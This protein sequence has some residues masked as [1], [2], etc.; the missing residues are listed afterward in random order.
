MHFSRVLKIEEHSCSSIIMLQGDSYLKGHPMSDKDSS[1]DAMKDIV[2]SNT[3]VNDEEAEEFAKKI[4][5][6]AAS[7][8]GVKI[9][10]GTF[11]RTTLKK[12]CPEID[13][14]R[15]VETTP[16]EAGVSAE[17]I[18]IMA[19]MVIDF[20]TKKCAGLSFLAGVP[21]GVA[22]FGTVPADLAQYFAHVMR[23]EQKLAYLY[24]WQT[25]LDDTDEVDDETIMELVVLMGV[26]LQVGGAAATITKFAT[27][28]AQ[29][30]VAK[31]IQRQALTKTTFYPIMKSVLRVMGVQLTKETFA[32]TVSKAVPIV[33]GAV[34]GGL[35]YASFK[36]GAERLRKY[37]RAL[38][39]SGIDPSIPD[40]GTESN[41]DKVVSTAAVQTEELTVLAVERSK[42][43]GK[44][45][46]GQV[47]S[48][49]DALIGGA[50]KAGVNLSE[51]AKSAGTF[52]SSLKKGNKNK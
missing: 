29:T 22:L 38:P 46:I 24:G 26:M 15:A 18:D 6:R 10:R 30:G 52:I 2:I 3:N 51:G 50:K 31:T 7:L 33:G 43:A 1:E 5:T 23:V 36:P 28:V 35:T 12:Y 48:A 13:S 8:N 41:F 19:Q 49:S 44:L 21:G 4:I 47:R 37:L 17:Q 45:A 25:F 11:L 16:I 34:S 20:E 14:D 39:T 9:N 40:E 27:N 42:S 32:K